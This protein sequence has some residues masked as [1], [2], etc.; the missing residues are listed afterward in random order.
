MASVDRCGHLPPQFREF[1]R[2]LPTGQQCRLI[3]RIALLL[4]QRQIVQRVEDLSSRP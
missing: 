3:Q 2:Q 4:Q 1:L